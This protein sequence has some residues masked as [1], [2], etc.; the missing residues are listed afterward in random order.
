M[1]GKR[2][3]VTLIIPTFVARMKKLG[4]YV[5][6]LLM[7][8]GLAGCIAACSD[9]FREI[10]PT[11]RPILIDNSASV[12]G[13]SNAV[14]RQFRKGGFLVWGVNTRQGIFARGAD[15][16]DTKFHVNNMWPAR[17]SYDSLWTYSP[18]AEW[19]TDDRLT[20]LAA[21]PADLEGSGFSFMND[22]AET[23]RFSLLFTGKAV[24]S[25]PLFV[26]PVQQR[27]YSPG[28]TGLKFSFD[29][30]LSRMYFRISN[31][32]E[33]DIDSLLS[34]SVEGS[35]PMGGKSGA[36]RILLDEQVLQWENLENG[37]LDFP[38][39]R[40]VRFDADSLPIGKSAAT[41]SDSPLYFFPGTA[42]SV[43]FEIRYTLRDSVGVF[44][45]YAALSRILR[46]E[47]GKNYLFEITLVKH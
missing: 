26:A 2:S 28:G 45:R 47:Q 30:M 39:Q 25:G 10:E 15:Y 12:V 14:M 16:S 9:E 8:A 21:A 4:R 22:Y 24:P 6:R 44:V 33:V 5:H 40:A 38:Q 3:L 20:L 32:M 43:R 46:M 36:P 29:D 17:V 42:D 1:R 19:T 35:F 18:L 23:R 37:H 31:E 27:I 7:V 34:V 13:A 11:G 41:L